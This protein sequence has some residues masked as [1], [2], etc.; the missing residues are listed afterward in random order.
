MA[1]GIKILGRDVTMTIGGASGTG[2]TNKGMTFNNESIDVT[3]DASGGW[4][5]LAATSGLK[6][7]EVSLTGFVKNLEMVK[8]YFQT[9]NMVEIV[10]T[11]PDNSTVTGD[12][13]LNNIN[14]SMDSNGQA[15]F[16]ASF[17]SSGAVVFVAGT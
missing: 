1:S 15:S 13:F 17:S 12:F 16:D 10:Q 9:S 5:E 4:T 11:Y 7:A 6:N 3:D 2:V 8:L 14:Y